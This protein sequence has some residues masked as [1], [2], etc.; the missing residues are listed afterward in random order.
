LLHGTSTTLS[1]WSIREIQA[2]NPNSSGR[3]RLEIE[4]VPRGGSAVEV[5][6]QAATARA[7]REIKR[8][9]KKV[10]F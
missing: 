7:A 4:A 5:Q 3:N 6:P 2:K 1:T 8:K 9:K 10:S